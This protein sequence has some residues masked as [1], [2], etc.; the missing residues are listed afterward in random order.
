MRTVEQRAADTWSREHR[1][2]KRHY[3]PP[4]TPHKLSLREQQPVA[5]PEPKHERRSSLWGSVKNLFFK[6]RAS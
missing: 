2:N 4:I 5:K 1:P 3:T 6:G